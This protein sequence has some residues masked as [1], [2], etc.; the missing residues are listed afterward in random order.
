SQYRLKVTDYTDSII[1]RV[2]SNGDNA[3][4]KT[5]PKKQELIDQISGLKKGQWIKLVGDLVYDNFLNDT[6]LEPTI[7]EVADKKERQDIYDGKK[8]IEL[9]VHTQMS[10]LDGINSAS[11]Y[12][13]RAELWGHE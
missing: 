3:K 8:R 7:L 10:P 13:K 4:F 9:N 5:S 11:D 6:V 2:F 12:L 1:V